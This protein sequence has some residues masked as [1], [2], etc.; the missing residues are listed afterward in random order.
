MI[1]QDGVSG[2]TSNPSIFEKAIA[3]SHDYDTAICRLAE[4]G[5]SPPE[6]YQ[7]LT[8]SDIRTTADLFY[9]LYKS[10]DGR[11]G[12]V[13]LE[14]NPHLAHDTEGTV[15]EA[16]QLW[17]YVDRPNL[18]I[19]VPATREGLPA[20]KQLIGEGINVNITLLFGLPRYHEVVEAYLAGLETLYNRGKPTRVVASVA[21]FFL[22]R[23]DALLDPQFEK[24]IQENRPDAKIGS[25]LHGQVAIHSA[26]AAYAIYHEL[27]NSRRWAALKREGATPQRLLWAST[28]T[29]NPAYSDVKY[30]E[31]LIGQDTINTLPLET[32]EAYRDHGQPASRLVDGLEYA[33]N[34]LASLKD[35][36]IDLD[37]ITQQLENEGVEK[38]IKAYD[39]LLDVLEQKRVEAL[40]LQQMC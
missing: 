11:D 21:S 37:A 39:K 1:D 36:G 38:F 19:K 14:V 24:M 6:M 4:E 34:S 23:I 16:R 15:R 10:L 35:I 17:S 27:F 25:D 8:V 9:P 33:Q 20:I 3:E 12:F 40:K 7:G 13:S 29:K 28:S 26:K 31:P 2:V 18:M 32:L 30:I 5:Q 22:S